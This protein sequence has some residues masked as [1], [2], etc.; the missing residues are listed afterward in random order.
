MIFPK[1]RVILPKGFTSKGYSEGLLLFSIPIAAI[2]FENALSG[3]YSLAAVIQ[4]KIL[5]F[6]IYRSMMKPLIPHK[7]I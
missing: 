4:A 7:V 6:L 3:T 2:D 5:T 1:N